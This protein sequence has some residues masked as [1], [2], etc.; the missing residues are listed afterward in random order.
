MNLGLSGKQGE[1]TYRAAMTL[2]VDGSG[3]ET[4]PRDILRWETPK[5]A[6]QK[7]LTLRSLW[8]TACRIPRAA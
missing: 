3:L 7:T 8:G 4:D 6:T 5:T 1:A 2:L